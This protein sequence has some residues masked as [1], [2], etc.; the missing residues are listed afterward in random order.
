LEGEDDRKKI[1]LL[2]L[3]E[4]L[5]AESGIQ[6]I[7]S[8]IQHELPRNQDD[9][10]FAFKPSEVIRELH[11]DGDDGRLFKMPIF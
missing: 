10:V 8:A 4:R 1:A 5:C 11:D 6:Y 2:K 3:V 9:S 7:M